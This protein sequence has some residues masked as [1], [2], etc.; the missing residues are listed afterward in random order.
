MAVRRELSGGLPLV[1]DARGS[2]LRIRSSDFS[3]LEKHVYQRYPRRE[4]GTFFEFGFRRTPWGLA[5]SYVGGLWPRAGDMDRQVGLTRFL[6]QYSRRA[7][8]HASESA[9][10]IGVVHSHPEECGTFPS[11]TDDDMDSYFAQ[12]FGSYGK[13]K[14]YC[15]LVLQRSSCTGFAFT[16]RVYDRGEWFPVEKLF[17]VGETIE[18]FPSEAVE[19]RNS[20]S[21]PIEA[22]RA[23]LVS[24]LGLPSAV[25]LRDATVGIIGCSG[26]GS[27]GVH[28][29]ARAGVGNFVLVDPQRFDDSNLERM[30]GSLWEHTGIEPTPYKVVL[31]AA[32]IRSINPKAKITTLV[33][34]ILHENVVDE[35]LRCDLLLGCTDTQ[36]G[37][38][39]LSDLAQHYL[40]PSIDL[41][42]LMEG[43]NGKVISQVC[44]ITVYSPDLPCAFC[45][46][47]IDG[48]ELS[49]ELTSEEER[50]KRK[51]EAKE[52]AERGDD[53]DQ[54]W[55]QRP[56]QLHTVGYLTTM[57][58]AL[59]AG[60]AEGVLTGAFHPPHSWFQF[61]IGRV[62]LGVVAP[63]RRR[64]SDCTCGTYLG[65]ADAAA[66]YRNVTK[67]D[68][69][70]KRAVLLSRTLLS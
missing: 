13:G 65:W 60:Y 17:S 29:L 27:P 7:F 34:N 19:D 43:E 63:P 9:L 37:R 38:A 35:L 52:A 18:M 50:A 51:L 69:W 53:P 1:E 14:P 6:D 70:P 8:H 12:E 5:L 20:R 49:N 21:A 67:P 47:R 31:V 23:R 40:L 58:G 68:H 33:G 45:T 28:V 11:P 22:A 2:L 41:G 4:W 54:Y 30:H 46:Q 48:I 25:R 36:H 44:D 15:S 57:L 42:V 24:L 64:A 66:P 55:R 16:G 32:L 62:R 39:K 61:D 3:R 59:G 56:R 26:T 10:A